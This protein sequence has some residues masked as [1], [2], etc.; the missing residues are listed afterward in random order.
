MSEPGRRET[1]TMRWVYG[2]QRIERVVLLRIAAPLAILGFMS[3][4]LAH[5][6]HWI[7]DAGFWVP[8]LGGDWRQPLYLP[9]L[10]VPLAW[11]LAGAMVASGVATLVGFRTRVSALVFGAT[12]AWV[13]LAD[14]LSAFTVSKLSPMIAITIA[15]SAG[16]LAYGVSAARREGPRPTHASGGPIRFVQVLLPVFYCASGICKARGDWLSRGDVLWT[17]LEGSYQTGFSHFLANHLPASAWT[18][19]QATTLA[20]EALAPLWFAWKPTRH[21]ALLYGLGMHAMI[22][23]MFGPVIWFSLLMMTL[24]VA[25]YLPEPWLLRAFAKAEGLL[26]PKRVRPAPAD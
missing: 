3:T 23:L 19:F 11:A 16:G 8:D 17:H 20:F 13:A 18:L 24:L 5:A 6:D 2:P 7:G 10:P 21:V 1:A 14:R 25:A 12:L 4:R 26:R 9:A 22:G 15:A